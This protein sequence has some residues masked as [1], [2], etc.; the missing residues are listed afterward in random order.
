MVGKRKREAETRGCRGRGK[1]EMYGKGE[2]RVRGG[3]DE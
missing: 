2:G 3:R 1:G